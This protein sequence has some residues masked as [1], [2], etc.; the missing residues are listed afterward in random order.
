MTA[1]GKGARGAGAQ[2]APLLAAAALVAL[3]VNV[4]P[5][6]PRSKKPAVATWKVLQTK[7]LFDLDWDR[8]DA[9]LCKHWDG[10]ENGL[11]AVTGSVSGIVVVDVDDDAARSRVEAVCGWP[12]TVTVRT[13][14]G[15]HL[16]FQRP[17][18]DRG[19]RVRVQDVRLDARADRGYAVVPP[20]VHPSGHVYTWEISP[21]DYAGGMWPPAKMPEGLQDLLWEPPPRPR[22][23]PLAVGGSHGNGYVAAAVNAEAAAVASAGEGSRNDT[24][25]KAAFALGR[26]VK[27]GELAA[28]QAEQTLLSAA[29]AAGLPERE[30]RATVWS[31][32][33]SR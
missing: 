16:W 27:G 24:L 31:G 3:R 15:W 17:G 6:A 18:G 11:A 2:P 10:T 21:W 20:S 12:E 13:S 33:R 14:K 23:F 4:L 8:V 5:L 32:L 22:R 30:A 26:F 9:W 25:N 7:N 19:N 1:N 29:A 28:S